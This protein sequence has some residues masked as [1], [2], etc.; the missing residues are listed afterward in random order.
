MANVGDCDGVVAVGAWR[1]QQ[2]EMT[3]RW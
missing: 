1:L 3:R 2:G